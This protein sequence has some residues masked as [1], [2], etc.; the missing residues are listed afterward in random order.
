M[1]ERGKPQRLQRPTISQSG[2]YGCVIGCR[3]VVVRA[4]RPLTRGTRRRGIGVAMGSGV[5][6]WSAYSRRITSPWSIRWVTR[7]TQFRI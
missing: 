7:S 6:V 5:S 4:D 1:F 3:P 2:S